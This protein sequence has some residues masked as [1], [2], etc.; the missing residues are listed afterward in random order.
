MPD[1]LNRNL[2]ALILKCMHLETLS[3]YRPIRLC[4]I[5]YKLITKLIVARIRPLLPD[6]ISPLQIVFVSGRKGVDNAI[7][8]QELVHTISRM[9][10][11]CGVMPSRLI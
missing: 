6:I 9:K 8:V 5:V 4:N 1:F 2:I 11:K 10:G 3:N 7:I